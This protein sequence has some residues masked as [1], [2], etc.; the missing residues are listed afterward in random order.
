[1]DSNPRPYVS[2]REQGFVVC[3]LCGI[4]KVNVV[5]NVPEFPEFTAQIPSAFRLSFLQE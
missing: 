5:N 4:S 3:V 1:M 2:S